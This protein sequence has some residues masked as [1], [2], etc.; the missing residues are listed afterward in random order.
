[1]TDWNPV[2]QWQE[3]PTPARYGPGISRPRDG[4]RTRPYKLLVRNGSAQ[5]MRVTLLASTKRD[6]LRYGQNRWPD[7]AVEVLP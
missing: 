1:M 5:P 2:L 3:E 7:A 6:A 4:Q